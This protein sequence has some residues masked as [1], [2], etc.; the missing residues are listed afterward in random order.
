[1]HLQDALRLLAIS[2]PQM[3]TMQRT[4]ILA[5]FFQLYENAK[6]F[7]ECGGVGCDVLWLFFKMSGTSRKAFSQSLKPNGT[8]PGASMAVRSFGE[9]CLRRRVMTWKVNLCVV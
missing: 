7:A 6:K 9:T 5:Q 1:M 8:A 4:A 2:V 3:Q